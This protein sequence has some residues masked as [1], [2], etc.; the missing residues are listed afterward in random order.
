MKI[1]LGLSLVL[2]GLLLTIPVSYIVESTSDA[3]F[4]ST[5]H[6]MK[7][8]TDSY[9]ASKHGGNN[10]TGFRAKCTDC[11]LPQGNIVTHLYKKTT[12]SINDVAVE[13]FTNVDDID[14]EEKRANREKFTFDSGC[15]KCHQNFDIIHQADDHALKAHEYY[16]KNKDKH[17]CTLCHKSVGHQNLSEHL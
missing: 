13:L 7:P 14:W 16:E 3:K 1:I 11:H 8:M 2:I 12:T 10:K 5:C 15:L 6:S 9:Y 4:C 17:G